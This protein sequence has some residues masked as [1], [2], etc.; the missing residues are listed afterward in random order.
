MNILDNLGIYVRTLRHL[1]PIQVFNRIKR[2]M[3]PAK[4]DLSPAPNI[5]HLSHEAFYYINK[6]KS[7][8]GRNHF[9]F[10]NIK[11]YLTFPEGWNDT[12]YPKIWL[13]NLHYFE[14]LLN[15]DTPTALKK[16]FIEQWVE[17]NSPGKGNGWEPYPNSLRIVN[18]IKWSLSGNELSPDVIKSLAIQVRY[19]SSTL[20]YHLLGN[21]LFVNI[22]ALVFAGIFFEG[23]EADE[24]FQKGFEKLMKEIPEQFLADGAHFE[25]SPTYHALLTEDL[26]DIVNI[27]QVSKKTVP[28]Q[29][30]KTVEK[31]IRWM[32]VMTRPDGLPPLFNDSAYGISPNIEEI[33]VYAN[34]IGIECLTVKKQGLQLLSESGYFRH[35]E[36]KYSIIGDVGQIGPSYQ[37]AHTHCDMMNF[38]L[39][40]NGIPIIVDT[41]TSTY[42]VGLQR[43]L[44]RST[45]A[46]NTVQ[47]QTH[48]Q[49]EIWG[50]F[51]VGRR[52]KILKRRVGSN[53]IEA[54]HDGYKKLGAIH[55]RNFSFYKD[56]IHINDIMTGYDASVICRIHLHPEIKL[57]L[58]GEKVKVGHVTLL[59]ENASSVKIK[60]YEYA[61]EFNKRITAKVIEIEF[62]NT[63]MTYIIL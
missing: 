38:E 2:R 16:H 57:E 32:M 23:R 9:Y 60:D 50:G 25:L 19:L 36:T 44:E 63:L 61:P 45:A 34:Q 46:H 28:E 8:I 13:Y 43:A 41:G 7:I 4:V 51:R 21:H 49:S 54:S 31:A 20:E 12:N 58:N 40:S 10:L 48:E 3:F 30:I 1:K 53:Y 35:D 27:L 17:E 42:E 29:W 39:F 62:Y 5:R 59:F 55:I 26:L 47:I 22:K 37:P 14:G 11:G 24:W 15:N 6:H 18:W 33:V 52:A 56:K